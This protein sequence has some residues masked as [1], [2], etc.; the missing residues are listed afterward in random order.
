[1]Q[2]CKI[3]GPKYQGGRWYIGDNQLT[4][5]EG[6]P[7]HIT[8]DF[9]C[10]F[11]LLTS[12]VGGPQHVDEDYNCTFNRLTDLVGCASHIGDRMIFDNNKITSLIGIH[13]IIKS[14]T[15]MVFDDNKIIEGGIGLL[16]IKNLTWISSEYSE[17][18]STIKSYLGSGTK[19]MMACSKELISKGYDNYAKL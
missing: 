5:L 8:G 9:E 17:P 16:L 18:L 15:N 4:S 13:K 7:N 11:N 1:M 12:L 3:L 14:C 10:R 6:S 19:G 2:N